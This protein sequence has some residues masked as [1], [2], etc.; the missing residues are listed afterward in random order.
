MPGRV[1]STIEAL[2]YDVE[3]HVSAL[4]EYLQGDGTFTTGSLDIQLDAALYLNELFN[5]ICIKLHEQDTLPDELIN[6]I[7]KTAGATL[8]NFM[9]INDYK[10]GLSFDDE[11]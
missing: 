9:V 5:V 8:L 3:G 10:S 1:R 4:R 7:I 6:T 11:L 2:L